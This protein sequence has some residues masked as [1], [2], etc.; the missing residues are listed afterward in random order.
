V[1]P[2]CRCRRCCRCALAHDELALG[3]DD[4]VGISCVPGGEVLAEERGGAAGPEEE[5][6][7]EAH[8]AN[9]PAHRLDDVEE[10]DGEAHLSGRERDRSRRVRAQQ[11]SAD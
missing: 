5:A 1:R 10:D 2:T 9:T 11:N 4:V 3:G 8:K 6:D 7:A